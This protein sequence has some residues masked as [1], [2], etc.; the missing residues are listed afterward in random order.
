MKTKALVRIMLI[1]FP[2][3]LFPF[4]GNSALADISDG[5]IVRVKHLRFF[6]VDIAK[7]AGGESTVVPEPW[8]DGIVRR[9]PSNSGTLIRLLSEEIPGGWFRGEGRVLGD[10]GINC[11]V[12]DGGQSGTC[13]ASFQSGESATLT[14][15]ADVGSFF[16]GW[17]DD[18][19]T[20]PSC[21]IPMTRDVTITAMSE[22]QTASGHRRL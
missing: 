13:T 11:I 21:T 12:N 19:E 10:N 15:T 6:W 8:L 17:N 5:P 4:L 14:A 22:G 18:C 2:F 7:S 3:T 16:A 9:Q 20:S 1:S